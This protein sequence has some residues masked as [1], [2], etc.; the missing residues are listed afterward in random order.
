[1]YVGAKASQLQAATRRKVQAS[2]GHVQ[3]LADPLVEMALTLLYPERREHEREASAA[4][5]VPE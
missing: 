5:P 4:A 1:M 2:T 3:S